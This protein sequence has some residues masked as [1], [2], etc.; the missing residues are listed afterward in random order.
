MQ[1]IAL[2]QIA[3]ASISPNR[4][5]G[6]TSSVLSVTKLL[7][8][9]KKYNFKNLY[10]FLNRDLNQIINEG[11]EIESP[12]LVIKNS[13]E[14]APVDVKFDAQGTKI[15]CTSMDNSLKVFDIN[16][17]DNSLNETLIFDS[18]SVDPNN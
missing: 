12:T 10:K 2:N 11:R 14:L 6:L 15:A 8:Y 16:K 1:D 13:I 7:R 17:V 3:M 4:L 18:N 5:T 9:G